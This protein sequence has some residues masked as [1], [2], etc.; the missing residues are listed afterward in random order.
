MHEIMLQF[1]G[2][3]WEVVSFSL[4]EVLFE[5]AQEDALTPKFRGTLRTM[6]CAVSKK[7]YK[8]R[9]KSNLIIAIIN[10]PQLG[11]L[12]GRTQ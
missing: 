10:L 9:I 8:E 12:N 2:D 7:K 6:C 4:L 1:E 3:G 11:A 5:E